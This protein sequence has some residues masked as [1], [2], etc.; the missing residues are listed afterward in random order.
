[1]FQK[2]GTDYWLARTKKALGSGPDLKTIM[3][4]FDP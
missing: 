4:T 3:L 1:M 2:M